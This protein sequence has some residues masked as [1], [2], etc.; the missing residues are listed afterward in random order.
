MLSYKE[1]TSNAGR[2]STGTQG[3]VSLP[4]TKPILSLSLTHTCTT[5][6]ISWDS[7]HILAG[8]TPMAWSI[9]T[10]VWIRLA[11]QQQPGYS[12]RQFNIATVSRK[13]GTCSQYRTPSHDP[14][15]GLWRAALCNSALSS[16]AK[17]HHG[18]ARHRH[19]SHR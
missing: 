5:Y 14:R 17:I 19:L 9:E 13:Q 8:P 11:S 7:L 10:S 15:N 3:G 4:H 1:H 2:S 18:T 6:F 12:A 16:A